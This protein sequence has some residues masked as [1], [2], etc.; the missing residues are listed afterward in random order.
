MKGAK[1]QVGRIFGIG[2]VL[3]KLAGIC[4]NPER[5]RYGSGGLGNLGV[6]IVLQIFRSGNEGVPGNDNIGS[7]KWSP[8]AIEGIQLQSAWP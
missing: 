3:L 7:R 2:D 4:D 6:R 1:P 5:P 8:A